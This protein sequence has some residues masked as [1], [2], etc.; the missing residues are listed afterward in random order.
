MDTGGNAITKYSRCAYSLSGQ[1]GIWPNYRV[2]GLRDLATEA[3]TLIQLINYYNDAD[4]SGNVT[5]RYRSAD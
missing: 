4:T 2:Y 1:H 3:V 5:V